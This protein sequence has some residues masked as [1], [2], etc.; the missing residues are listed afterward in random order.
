[1]HKPLL[2]LLASVVVSGCASQQQTLYAWGG[3]DE[4]LHAYYKHPQ[5]RERFVDNLKTVVLQAEQEG[6]KVPPGIYAEYGYALYE[7]GQYG[8]AVGYFKKEHELWPESRILMDKMIRNA[9]RQGSRQPAAAT[10]P[11]GAVAKG[12]P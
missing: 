12:T 5:E 4:S 1:M 10:G 2:V 9:Q 11:A 6:R 3:Y 8:P 7:E